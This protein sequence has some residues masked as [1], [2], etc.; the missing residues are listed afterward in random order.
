MWRKEKKRFDHICANRQIAKVHSPNGLTTHP[1][2][3][4][5]KIYGFRVPGKYRKRIKIDW[6]ASKI[7]KNNYKKSLF[8][9]DV[10]G[11]TG[12]SPVSSTITIPQSRKALRNF[13]LPEDGV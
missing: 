10:Q 4:D 1:A 3:V 7:S 5:G 13:F 12:S 2:T 6:K 11:V 8:S 9:L